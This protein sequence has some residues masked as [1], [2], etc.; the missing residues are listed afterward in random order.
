MMMRNVRQ[1]FGYL[2]GLIFVLGYSGQPACA[3]TQPQ[4]QVGF[5]I[6][7]FG[8]RVDPVTLP[9]VYKVF[10]KIRAVAELDNHDLPQLVIIKDLPGPPAIVLPD[11]NLVIAEKALDVI[12]NGVPLWEGNTRLAFVLG[13][14]LAHLASDDSWSTEVKYLL[15]SKALSGDI[16]DALLEQMEQNP[17]DLMEKELKADDKGF[18]YAAMAGF[19]VEALLVSENDFLNY[20]V[21]ETRTESSKV[22]P[23]A[24]Q[25]TE[26]LRI[27]LQQKKDALEFF[28]TG[29]RL[30]HFGR[31]KDATYF[32]QKFQEVFPG[33]EVFN[34]LGVCYLLMALKK[35]PPELAHKYW[36][37]CVLDSDTII[38]RSGVSPIFRSQN[39]TKIIQD[40]LQQAV[41]YF[42]VAT[43]K[44]S[45]YAAG[46]TNLAVAYF[47]LN[48]FYKAR[49]AVEEAR[50]LEPNDYEIESLR[51]LI[52]L[53]EG[54]PMDTWPFAE[55]IFNSLASNHGEETLPLSV[56]YNW[57]KLLETRGRS[58]ETQWQK[59]SKHITELPPSIAQVLCERLN[60][61]SAVEQCLETINRPAVYGTTAAFPKSL[62]VQPGFDAWQL[63]QAEHPLNGWRQLP[64]HWQGEAANTGII[65][66]SPKGDIV[67]EMND[68]VEMLVLKKNQMSP[69]NLLQLSGQPYS[70]KTTINGEL[71]SYGH[72]TALIHEDRIR[73][74]WVVREKL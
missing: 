36:L 54:Q 18:L 70:K 44:D 7:N 29:V 22:H 56:Y 27:R 30:I 20:W 67:L 60:N 19:P 48:E 11:G 3:F 1:L 66:H 28:Y 31:Y 62:P 74:L 26:L 42:T 43:E 47:Y 41:R 57:A 23:D 15:Q 4:N 58:A 9:Q 55:K 50:K 33:R 6:E 45:A 49:A 73:E 65:Y 14:E 10:A 53:E 61:P 46:Y 71:W 64:F 34:N 25:R 52:L 37:P 35:M 59:L 24:T 68:V 51:A 2:L 21:T 8:G 63:K 17:K 13:H 39:Q 16:D 69:Q 32:F 12:Y 5:Y 38:N 72:W 40:F